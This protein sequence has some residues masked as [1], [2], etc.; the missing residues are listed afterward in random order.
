[1]L[2]RTRPAPKIASGPGAPRSSASAPSWPRIS[3]AEGN[4]PARRSAASSTA[5][6]PAAFG[7]AIEVP[8][9]DRSPFGPIRR[10]SVGATTSGLRRPSS[11]GPCDE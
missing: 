3:P 4:L 7:A 6:A 11:L 2:T 9:T 1:M 8:P 5:A 10:V